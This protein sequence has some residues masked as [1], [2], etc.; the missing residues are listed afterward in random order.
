[1]KI[2]TS[3]LNRKPMNSPVINSNII[4]PVGTTP[5]LVS[6]HIPVIRNITV[7]WLLIFLIICSFIILNFMNE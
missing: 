6:R 4:I 7:A 1:M 3:V 5:L 2:I